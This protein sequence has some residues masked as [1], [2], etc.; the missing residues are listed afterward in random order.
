MSLVKRLWSDKK[1]FV[2]TTELMLVATILVIGLIVGL[3]GAR[4]AIVTEMADVGEAIGEV[5]QTYQYSGVQG[6]H[7]STNGSAWSDTAD[8]CELGIAA[9]SGINSQCVLVCD[10]VPA[11][12]SAPALPNS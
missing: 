9:Q 1:G 11:G 6:H 12:E 2:V 7:A 4:V 8:T 10:D 5:S 3:Q